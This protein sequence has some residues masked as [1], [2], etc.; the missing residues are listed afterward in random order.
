MSVVA[1]YDIDI[2]KTTELNLGVL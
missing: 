2:R 1:S